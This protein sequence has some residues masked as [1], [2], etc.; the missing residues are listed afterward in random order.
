MTNEK[1]V[2]REIVVDGARAVNFLGE[3]L[4]MYGTPSMIA[5]IET[6]CRELVQPHL[7]HGE[8]TVGTHLIVEHLGPAILGDVVR[9][10][11]QVKE[12]VG[13]VIAFEAKIFR[14]DILIG[15]ALHRRAVVAL[16]RLKTKLNAL[17]G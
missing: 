13:G 2:E 11:I 5:D 14:A 16:D 4:R 3:D 12:H 1:T 10:S 6:G 8:D 9:I 7:A 17:R 15:T